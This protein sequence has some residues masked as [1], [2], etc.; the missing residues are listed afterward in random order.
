[1]KRRKRVE[2]VLNSCSRKQ[3]T[4]LKRILTYTIFT[5]N[6]NPFKN[7]V[8]LVAF[9]EGGGGEYFLQCGKRLYLNAKTENVVYCMT[10]PI[11]HVV[12]RK[13]N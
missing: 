7:A 3:P 10:C 8:I 9:M 5:Y 4:R 11:C 12:Y 1:M 6:L 13:I 2:G